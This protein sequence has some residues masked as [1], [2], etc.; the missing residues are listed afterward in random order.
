MK[1]FSDLIENI[2][3]VKKNFPDLYKA[4]Y[5][6]VKKLYQSQ[7]R[8]ESLDDDL[9]QDYGPTINIFQSYILSEHSKEMEAQYNRG[10]YLEDD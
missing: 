10:M 9:K 4:A 2:E 3:Y 8:E 5:E 7:K 6:K 1:M